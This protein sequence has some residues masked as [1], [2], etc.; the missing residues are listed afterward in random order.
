[1]EPAGIE[2]DAVAGL[3]AKYRTG[4]YSILARPAAPASAILP[5]MHAGL[6][7]FHGLAAPMF[8]S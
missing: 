6:A 4:L 3:A 1:M 5:T 7:R 2:S 8:I